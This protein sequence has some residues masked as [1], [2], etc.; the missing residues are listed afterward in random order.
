MD[1]LEFKVVGSPDRLGHFQ[2]QILLKRSGVVIDETIWL[3]AF[4]IISMKQ[5]LEDWVKENA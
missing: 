5:C 1:E 4:Q 3:D 2:V